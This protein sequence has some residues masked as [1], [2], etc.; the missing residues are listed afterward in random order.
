MVVSI[1]KLPLLEQRETQT[2]PSF[3][4]MTVLH[5]QLAKLFFRCYVISIAESCVCTL[6]SLVIARD[7][8]ESRRRH[9]K[10]NNK[11]GQEFNCHWR[12]PPFRVKS[13]HD[14]D[15]SAYGILQG[16]KTNNGEQHSTTSKLRLFSL[17]REPD[18]V[19]QSQ[20]GFRAQ[21]LLVFLQF[22]DN[23]LGLPASC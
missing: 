4:V 17:T 19:H 21:T 8:R 13:L 16:I 23:T 22:P 5:Q 9:G 11:T 20:S 18:Q 12:E 1:L 10:T 2:Q 3:I 7:C 6:V 15:L 14:L